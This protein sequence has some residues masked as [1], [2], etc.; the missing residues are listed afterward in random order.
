[1]ALIYSDSGEPLRG[2]GTYIG[3]VND[4]VVYRDSGEPLKGWGTYVGSVED[5]II[6]S[7]SGEPFRGYGTYRG[8]GTGLS[9]TEIAA[10]AL[11]L[12][13]L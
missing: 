2:Y 5:G 3:S 11:L 6:H 7:D 1:M 13:L 4:G 12:G 9:D 10:A 8:S